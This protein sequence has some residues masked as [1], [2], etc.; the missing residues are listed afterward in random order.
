VQVVK[1][2]VIKRARVTLVCSVTYFSRLNGKRNFKLNDV[3]K[4]TGEATVIK[5]KGQRQAVLDCVY[6]VQLTRETRPCTLQNES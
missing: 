6:G 3:E 5:K 1:G 4:I 2:D